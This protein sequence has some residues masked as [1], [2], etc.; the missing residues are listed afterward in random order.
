MVLVKLDSYMQKKEI[1]PFSYTITQKIK[2]KW[3]KDL[4]MS[5][6]AIKILEEIIGSNVSDIG[7]R[8]VFLD[9]PPMIRAT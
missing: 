7:H 6:E 5:P 4:S 3:I 2:S 8:N 1:G 9:M